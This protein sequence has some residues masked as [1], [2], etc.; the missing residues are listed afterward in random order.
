[1]WN[2]QIASVGRQCLCRKSDGGRDRIGSSKQTTALRLRRTVMRSWPHS[3]LR[4]FILLAC[5]AVSPS[6]LTQ[7]Q[8]GTTLS[9]VLRDKR[10]DVITGASVCLYSKN[11]KAKRTSDE[12]G[13]FE[14]S[15]LPPG[16]YRLE[17][18]K[19]GFET[20]VV[21]PLHIKLGEAHVPALT[22]TMNVA[23]M[24]SCSEASSVS[25]EERKP[26]AAPL[27]GRIQPSPPAPE[28]V[29]TWPSA[30]QPPAT[31][32]Y[33]PFSQATVELLKV[34]GNQVVASTHPNI[35]GEFEFTGLQIG[36][37]VLRARYKGY[38]DALS[39]KFQ[40]TSEDVTTVMVP[41]QPQ[42]EITI[43]W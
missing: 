40:I 16:T 4:I 14:F 20:A 35:H 22:I 7:A 12:T 2:S 33:V 41:M 36:A 17:A 26:D 1:M 19:F 28:P 21:Q 11:K 6:V 42:G 8:S 38:A 29:V 31:W 5:V 10:G 18:K 43:C 30:P 9:G 23:V 39:A 24:D 34:D 3:C 32:P 37:Y 25:Y 27:V 13:Q 15:N